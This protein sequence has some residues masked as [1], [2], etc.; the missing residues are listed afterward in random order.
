MEGLIENLKESQKSSG[1]DK[2]EEESDQESSDTDE[3]QQA[4]EKDMPEKPKGT[5]SSAETSVEAQLE[6]LCLDYPDFDKDVIKGLLDDQGNDTEEVVR[7][8]EVDFHFL[9]F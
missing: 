5:P 1:D 4:S 6:A 2:D 9:E 3:E 8:L 7:Y